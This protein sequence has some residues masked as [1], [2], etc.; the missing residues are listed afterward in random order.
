MLSAFVLFVKISKVGFLYQF[1]AEI[2]RFSFE[3]GV[4][5]ILC[6]DFFSTGWAV[7]IFLILINY[8]GFGI[9]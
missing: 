4:G 5:C 1:F 9:V 2:S 7:Y 8:S 3:E 6:T